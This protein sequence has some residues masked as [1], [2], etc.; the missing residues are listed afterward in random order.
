VKLN[1]F[2]KE[3]ASKDCDGQSQRQKMAN[4]WFGRYRTLDI[5]GMNLLKQ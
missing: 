5:S 2:V 3:T 4:V 1:G